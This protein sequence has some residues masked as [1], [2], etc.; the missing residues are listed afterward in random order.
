MLARFYFPQLLTALF[1]GLFV[2]CGILTFGNSY[3]FDRLYIG[4]IIF[5]AAVCFRN[6]NIVSVLVIIL[7]QRCVEEA[8]WLG[9]HNAYTVKALLYSLAILISFYLRF[10]PL[11]R[12]V[13]ATLILVIGAELYWYYI[14]YPAPEIYWYVTILITNLCSRYLVF[15]RLEIVDGFFPSR[16]RS[17]NLDWI[18]YKLM[19]TTIIIQC[20]NIVEYLVRHLLGYSDVLII[21]YS[22][23]Y[24]MHSIGMFAIWATFNESYKQLLPKLMKA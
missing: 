3:I 12:Y 18:V 1:G 14:D 23:P 9:L 20:A 7:L 8:A 19:G 2:A 10:D 24:L 11:A 17:T 13:S 15:S 16:G 21:Y 6:I 22:Y 5:T 4:I